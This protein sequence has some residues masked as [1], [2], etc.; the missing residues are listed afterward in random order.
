[1]ELMAL[2]TG[3]KRASL[4]QVG[5]LYFVE[6]YENSRHVGTYNSTLLEEAKTMAETYVAEESTKQFLSE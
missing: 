1:M 4:R 2:R 6:M 5:N 3:N